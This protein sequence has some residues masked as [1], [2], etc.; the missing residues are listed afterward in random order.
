M[1]FLD[2]MF[3][4]DCEAVAELSKEGGPP[5]WDFAKKAIEGYCESLLNA[6]LPPT[7]FIVPYAAEKLAP[8]FLEIHQKGVE[9]ALHYH[10]QDHG[11][12]DYLGAYDYNEQNIML[13]EA[14]DIWSNALGFKPKSFRGGNFSANDYTYPVLYDLGFRQG[15]L[16]APGRSFTRVKSNWVSAPMLP[17]HTSR[18]N[19]LIPGDMDF[20]EVPTTVDWESSMWGGLTKLELRIEMVDARAHGF[21][22]RKNVD[23]QLKEGIKNPYLLALTHNIFDYSDLHEFRRMVLYDLISEIKNCADQRELTIRGF[24]LAGY[25]EV[26][27]EE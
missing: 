5:D 15:S 25:H 13:A 17:Y 4:M 22:V 1:A 6:G 7:L 16:S 19:R 2:V 18:A 27:K 21:T 10:P 24:T 23:R 11:R 12:E 14:V 8:F 20:L 3:T 26:F 9:L